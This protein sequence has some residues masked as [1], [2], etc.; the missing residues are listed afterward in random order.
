MS[1]KQDLS[2]LCEALEVTIN[3]FLNINFSD[4]LISDTGDKVYT[5]YLRN[6]YKFIED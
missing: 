1:Q 6:L 4:I 3:I 5:I 2:Y